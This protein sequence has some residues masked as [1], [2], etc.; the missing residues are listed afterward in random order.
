MIVL[1]ARTAFQPT[2]G[3]QRYYVE[4][5]KR[6]DFQTAE[7]ASKRFS[8]GVKGHCWEQL[9]LPTT[10]KTGDLLWSP[11]NTG[12]IKIR[13]Q[14]VTIHDL[15]TFENPQWFS[16]GFAQL[17]QY[18]LPRVIKKSLGIIAVS[19]FTKTSIVQRFD[20]DPDKISVIHNGVS[21]SFFDSNAIAKDNST[22][23]DLTEKNYF[24]TVGS[25]E[26]RK[27]LRTLLAAWEALG[28]RK[29]AGMRLVVVGEKNSSIFSDSSHTES[30]SS[31]LFTGR[32]SDGELQALYRNAR[33]FAYLSLYEGF[34]LPILEAAACG[35]PVLCSDI[36]PFKEIGIPFAT[37][38]DPYSVLDISKGI[39]DICSTVMTQ[40]QELQMKSHAA[41]FSWD[42]CAIK[43]SEVLKAAQAIV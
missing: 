4:V 39:L 15:A 42:K 26:P 27:N 41:T 36:A 18:V 3:V 40:S 28:S 31:V 13:N 37:Y 8:S 19:N 6:F 9:V 24:L 29:P 34:G 22:K 21:E 11:A 38:V 25:I 10:L 14:V 35:I 30:D 1:N 7:Q 32:L 2:T 16:R 33:G 23:F 17:Y 43:T 20:I 12:P 5:K